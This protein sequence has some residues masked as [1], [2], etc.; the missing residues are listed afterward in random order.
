MV[1]LDI[2]PATCKPCA[3]M[4][5]RLDCVATSACLRL[6]GQ[7]AVHSSTVGQQLWRQH[8]ILWLSSLT[9]RC[10]NKYSCFSDTPLGRGRGWPEQWDNAVG[11]WKQEHHESTDCMLLPRLRSRACYDIA[12]IGRPVHTQQHACPGCGR[13]NFQECWA[14]ICTIQCLSLIHI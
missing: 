5:G 4:Q 1:P 3:R 10:S 13:G 9:A 6:R 7:G 8:R 12:F 11:P 14:R 2:N